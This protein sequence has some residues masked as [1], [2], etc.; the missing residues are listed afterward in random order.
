[1][2]KIINV[3]HLDDDLFVLD[4]VKNALGK[5]ESSQFTFH[6]ASVE[7]ATEFR[8]HIAEKDWDV[9][10]LDIY[11][12]GEKETGIELLKEIKQHSSD[13]IVVMCSGFS[14]IEKVA[15]S[16]RIGADDFITKTTSD[17]EMAL[18][19]EHIVRLRSEKTSPA[20]PRSKQKSITYTG[21][22]MQKIA[23][24]VPRICQSAITAVHVYGETGTGKE[25]VAEL[26]M[27]LHDEL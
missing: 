10:I 1:M 21:S 13:A 26:Y 11:L 4:K 14:T 2:N 27:T 9:V 24:R 20:L 17:D 3:L 22:T 18:R 19:I 23:A 6:V 12:K 8:N 5:S 16:L 7:N 15:K 25:V